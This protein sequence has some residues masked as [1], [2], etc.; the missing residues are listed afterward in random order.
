MSPVQEI[1]QSFAIELTTCVEWKDY[2]RLLPLWYILMAHYGVNF[3]DAITLIESGDVSIAQ[4]RTTEHGEKFVREF[5]CDNPNLLLGCRVNNSKFEVMDRVFSWT[6]S[7]HRPD[8]L[9]VD[10]ILTVDQILTMPEYVRAMLPLGGGCP[11]LLH[12]DL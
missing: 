11:Q 10:G 4:K 2:D 6:L 3:P 7:F 12:T 8:R 5:V 1:S 9:R